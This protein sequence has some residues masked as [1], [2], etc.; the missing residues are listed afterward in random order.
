MQVTACNIKKYR[1]LK[2]QQTRLIE[3]VNFLKRCRM[4]GVYPNFIKVRV[5]VSN[6]RSEKAATRARKVWLQNELRFKYSRLDEVSRDLYF[7]FGDIMNDVKNVSLDLWHQEVLEIDRICSR[8]MY[9][10]KYVLN[11]KF[12]NLKPPFL[13]NSPQNQ[14]AEKPNFVVNL[15][16]KT[17]TETEM[18]FLNNGLKHKIVQ[19]FPPIDD[20]VVNIES[21]LDMAHL[22][23]TDKNEIRYQCKAVFDEANLRAP[24]PKFKRDDMKILKSIK[25]K[26]VFVM[27]PDK[28]KGVVIMN[29][30]DY[31]GRM[32]KT[33][34]EG[35]YI[36]MK[37]DGRWKDGS[38]LHKMENEVLSL[39]RD[40]MRNH[41][42]KRSTYNSLVVSNPKMP[43]MYGLPKTH[44]S[45]DKMRPIVSNIKTPTSKISK[46]VVRK[47]NDLNYSKGLTVKNSIDLVEKI[48][49]IELKDDEVLVSFDVVGLFPNV[50]LDV[51]FEAIE[52]FLNESNIDPNERETLLKLTKLCMTQ[53][54]FR[55][56]DKFYRQQSGVSIGNSASGMVSDFFMAFF[57]MKIHNEPWFP[58]WWFRYV[59]DILAIVKRNMLRETL[60][61][62]NSFYPSIQFTMEVEENGSIP[63][64]DLRIM[65]SG[66]K[67]E[68]SIYR[69]PTDSQ[70]LINANSF[71]HESHK[72]AAFHSMIHRLLNVPM[73]PENFNV[74]WKYIQETA[75]IN[76][77]DPK[78]IKRI[79]MKHKRKS[80]MRSATSLSTAEET[81]NCNYVGIPYYGALTE[82]LSRRL[83]QHGFKVGYQNPGKISDLLGS[84][85]DKI[86]DPLK[87]SGIYIL[88]CDNCEM[89]YIGMSK[90]SIQTRR[91]EHIG[92]CK[93]PLN[94]ESA[95]AY[96]CISENH[97]IKDVKLL[98]EVDEKHKLNRWESLELHKHK[99]EKLA[100]L[101][102]QGNS[103]SFLFNFCQSK[104]S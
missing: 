65:R 45:G 54:I 25:E 48:K 72:H 20:I 57:E 38:P 70:M 7:L 22:N 82:N 91:D 23:E 26:D 51:A 40:L 9:E 83:R 68:F 13:V 97:Q 81:S 37:I 33:I 103:P 41:G 56:R 29:K 14:I 30:D 104:K 84:S 21:A 89:K 67:L 74:E 60:D 16:D 15:S 99:D 98:K 50:P 73:S 79:F 47:F 46:Y 5:S 63:F 53:N 34:E 6:T 55:F 64:L 24:H 77:Y 76:G 66:E 75:A 52:K 44:K 4:N 96:H 43:V 95:M 2:M 86:E 62:L 93:K 87:K 100:N 101:Y 28:G 102:L 92:D 8:L 59:D 10:K 58:E 80:M 27:K 17:F 88:N 42:M 49:D 3:D 19:K 18:E 11:K 94:P 1:K 36:E 39:L 90:R 69:K 32:L 35:P 12:R 78:V 61:R 71:H 85:K 31:D